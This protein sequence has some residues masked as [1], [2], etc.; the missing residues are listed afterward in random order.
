MSGH[1]YA[2]GNGENSSI[3]IDNNSSVRKLLLKVVGNGP[4]KICLIVQLGQ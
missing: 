3:I 4:F 1:G 2:K